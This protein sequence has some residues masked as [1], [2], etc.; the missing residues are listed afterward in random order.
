MALSGSFY[1]NVGS[2]WRVYCTWSGSQSIS[3]NYTNITLKVYWEST[4][5]YG[6]THTTDTKSGSASINGSS[7]NFTFSA[8]LSGK[9]RKLVHTRTVRVNHNADGTKNN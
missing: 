3:G 2:H 1:K 8:K 5:S 6:T 7:G 4:D 9:Q